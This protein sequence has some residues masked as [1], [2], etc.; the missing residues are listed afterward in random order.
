[1]TEAK[2]VLKSGDDSSIGF[3]AGEA[4]ADG[5]VFAGSL[6]GKAIFTTPTDAPLTYTFNEAADFARQLN[7]QTFLAHDDWRV[8][9]KGELNVLYNNRT[10]IGGFN[11]GSYP[12]GCYWPSSQADNVEW[13]AW[14]Q[15]FFTGT[16]SVYGKDISASLRCVRG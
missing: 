15:W 9:T 11:A 16:Q 5:T 4:M 10:A 7:A 2:Q 1:M 6:N 3:G 8:P 13:G 12:K 14:N